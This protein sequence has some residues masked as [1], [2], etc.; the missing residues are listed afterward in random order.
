MTRLEA[1]ARVIC[2]NRWKVMSFT[3]QQAESF[4]AELKQLGYQVVPTCE[5]CRNVGGDVREYNGQRW[6]HIGSDAITICT[7]PTKR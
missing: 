1:L 5:G 3:I 7:M 4:E 6:H 2:S